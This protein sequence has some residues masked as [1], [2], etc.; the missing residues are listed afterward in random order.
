MHPKM[1][2][3]HQVRNSLNTASY[4][5]CKI[6]YTPRATQIHNLKEFYMCEPCNLLMRYTTKEEEVAIYLR[7]HKTLRNMRVAEFTHQEIMKL[8]ITDVLIR[9]Q[10]CFSRHDLM[11]EFCPQGSDNFSLP[12]LC[13][14]QHGFAP[15]PFG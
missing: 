9:M 15:S 5:K 14:R 12:I 13:Q 8:F 2:C 3:Y 1:V 10:N 7:K 6:P 4:T 11:C